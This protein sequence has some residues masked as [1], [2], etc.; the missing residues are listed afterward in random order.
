M[1]TL[2][3]YSQFHLK[4]TPQRIAILDCL[5]GNKSH[6][7][8]HDIYRAV[9]EKFPTVSLATVYNTL[10]ALERRGQLLKLTIDPGKARY[11]P[12]TSPHHHLICNLCKTIADVDTHYRPALPDTDFEVTG[13][14]VEFYGTC[15]KCRR[16]TRQNGN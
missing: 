12:N 8:A 9:A 13:S 2:K 3:K 6:P 7:S 5:E 15:P 11:D 1:S 10:S 16:S 4:L 14:H